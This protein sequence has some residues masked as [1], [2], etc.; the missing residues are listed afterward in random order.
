MIV[1]VNSSPLISLAKVAQFELLKKLFGKIYIPPT[2]WQEV[3]VQGKERPGEQ[4]TRRAVGKWI[5]KMTV[6]DEL[7]VELLLP[8]M[9]R[10]EAE[11]IVLAKEA[12]ADLVLLDDDDAR[13]EAELMGLNVKGTVAVLVIAFE[14]GQIPDLKAA[15]DEL[16]EKG[17]WMADKIYRD[18]L[19]RVLR[20][21]DKT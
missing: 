21:K 11:C 12:D 17:F 9:R 2:V 5:E 6:H 14:T 7:A 4:E 3:V 10:G 20:Q 13:T 15:L 19:R 8:T 1:V 16:R 18:V